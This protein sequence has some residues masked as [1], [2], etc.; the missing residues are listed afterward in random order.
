MPFMLNNRI[1][2]VTLFLLSYSLINGQS[3]SLTGSPYSLYGL[4]VP[5]NSNI[6]V[7]NSIG[8]GGYAFAMDGVI[9]NLNPASYGELRE[10]SFLLDFGFLAENSQINNGRKT[11]KRKASNF[12][13]LAFASSLS[14]KY[15]FGVSLNPYSDVGYALIG[16]E[17]N[18]EGSFD[19][20]SSNIRGQGA[21]NDLRVSVGGSLMPGFRLGVYVS[22][23]FGEIE[24]E[25]FVDASREFQ[26][27]STLNILEIN[28]YSGARIGFGLQYDYK[29]I[30]KL[31]ITTNLSSRLTGTQTRSVFK[32]LDFEGSI[33]EEE[34]ESTLDPFFLPVEVGVGVLFYP[35]T[36]MGINLDYSKS[37]WNQT[38]QRDNLGT[39]VDQEM[40]SLGM[41]YIKNP[42]SFKYTDRINYRLGLNYNTGNM[43]INGNPINSWSFTSGIGIPLGRNSRSFLNLSYGYTKRGS[44]QG[45]LVEEKYH[46][47]NINFSL[48]DI[49]FLKRQIN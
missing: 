46:T 13:N 25:E 9:N 30:F 20:F 48:R 40:Y 39:F 47:F 29:N 44:T 18:I 43:E 12:S 5:S 7:N 3:N 42:M 26:N 10:N 14:S 17:S 8:F 36:G 19:T 32:T 6:G 49:W 28:N 23:L 34:N 33:V 45:F 15:S 35:I 4:G 38:N 24:E 27:Q 31:G 41:Q 1:V 16:I 2:V 11:E 22:Y 37:F 21:L